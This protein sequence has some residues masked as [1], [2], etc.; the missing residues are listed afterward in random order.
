MAQSRILPLILTVLSI[1][2]LCASAQAQTEA[3]QDLSTTHF[4][5]T[6]VPD[7]VPPLPFPPGSEAPGLVA[8]I[9][10]RSAG[11]M[12]RKDSE[13]V[14]D[15]ESSINEHVG[16][17][18]LD[19]KQGAWTYQQVVCPALPN[20]LFLRFL[21]NDGTGDVSV[22]TASIPRNGEGRVRIIPI[23]LRGYSLFSPAPIN[24]LTISA[25]NHIRA[26]ENPD[27]I[28]DWFGTGLCYAALAG[29]HPQA[30]NPT[31]DT[32]T[33]KFPTAVPAV[34]QVPVQGGAFVSFTDAAA[35]PRPMEWT[36]T[37]DK[38]GRLLKATHLPVGL[39]TVTTLPPTATEMKGAPL[40]PTVEDIDAAG[41]V[42]K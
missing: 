42:V 38:K 7:A 35:A 5:V 27:K 15:A 2:A 24:A 17:I 25:F 13:L 36:M 39:L 34:L 40:P 32:E 30:A 18:G 28:P 37:F 14:A 8:P 31:E 4:K 22:F 16:R 10:F 19:F 9:E 3:A 21:R 1:A 6:P 11:E 23:Q 12:T 41:N 33:Q 26:E 29:A 20:H